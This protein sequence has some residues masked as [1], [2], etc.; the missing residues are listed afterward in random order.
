MR[1]A[2]IDDGVS[3]DAVYSNLEQYAVC[4]DCVCEAK[5][6][7]NSLSHGSICA[8]IIEKYIEND[9][10]TFISIQVLNEDDIGEISDLIAAL[11]WC[12]DQKID[13]INLSLGTP[14]CP[15]ANELNEICQFLCNSGTKIVAAS[16]NNGDLSYPAG[17][18]CVTSVEQKSFQ[19]DYKF[20]YRVSDVISEGEHELFQ[21]DKLFY[22][23][24]CNSFACAY[25][26]AQIANTKMGNE[27]TKGRHLLVLPFK[28]IYDFSML[29]NVVALTHNDY[30]ERFCF[31]YSLF[32]HNVQSPHTLLI[33]SDKKLSRKEILNW[34]NRYGSSLTFIVWCGHRIPRFLLRWCKQHSVK[35]WDESVN[36]SIVLSEPSEIPIV[37]FVGENNLVLETIDKVKNLLVRDGYN[38]MQSSDADKS[39]LYGMKKIYNNKS[40]ALYARHFKPDIILHYNCNK[41][42]NCYDIRISCRATNH[43]EI[44]TP[45]EVADYSSIGELYSTMIKLLGG[46]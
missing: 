36:S 39:Y 20:W 4:N 12:V 29:S 3:K 31:K 9:D 40:M 22:S 46:D 18:P 1:I 11:N 19:T 34:L 38:P 10:I 26:T 15:K 16:N 17:F 41:S 42:F 37:E 5:E 21:G 44:I 30:D 33:N 7:C 28:Q 6:P 23:E 24:K 45:N 32:P 35:F 27:K 2:I 43:L 14:P 8:K 13:I 25:V